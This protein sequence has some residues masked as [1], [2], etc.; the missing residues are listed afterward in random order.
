MTFALAPQLQR[1]PLPLWY[2]LKE[3]IRDGIV[4]GHLRPGDRLPTEQ[5]L[6]DGLGISRTPV[7]SA[8]GALAD[9]GLIVRIP[10]RG[11][12]VRRSPV[13]QPVNRLEGFHADM[14][15][16]GIE[17]S[18]RTLWVALADPD[19]QARSALAVESGPIVAVRRLL[20][21]DGE[22]MAVHRSQL[23][24]WV[25]G[26]GPLWD[27]DRLDRDSLYRL[28]EERSGSYPERAEETIEAEAADP[29]VAEELGIAP[30]R[31][32]LRVRR[33]SF[34]GAGRPVELVDLWYRADRYRY[35]VELQRP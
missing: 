29:K 34:D 3:R 4:E 16:R 23:P 26:D 31:P 9:E 15:A 2:Q 8:L 20:L 17:P 30:G 32:V 7:R 25:L 13:E 35:R 28:M 12:F 14:A 33:L 19:P 6:I 24:R 27:P 10:G 1:G 5:E 21:G 11:S 22:A 18:A